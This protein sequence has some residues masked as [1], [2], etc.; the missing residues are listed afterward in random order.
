[1]DDFP[2]PGKSFG[3]NP[4]VVLLI[5]G[6]LA[7]IAAAAVL[8][9]RGAPPPQ[10][11][12][13]ESDDKP[14][15]VKALVAPPPSPSESLGTADS[16]KEQETAATNTPPSK[17]DTKKTAAESFG[18]TIDAK[19][20]SAYIDGHFD[21]VRACYERRLKINALL[22]GRLDLNIVISTSGKVAAIGVN[23]DTVRDAEMLSCVKKTIRTWELPKPEGGRVV[24]GKTFS[25]K[26]KE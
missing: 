15:A 4:F 5:A 7:L 3:K 1:M 24:I 10:S 12:S 2:E 13:P 20:V 11:P 26:K 22:E 21:Q 25:F 9:F 16:E 8:F 18:G 6:G 14:M 19:A 17:E 23:S